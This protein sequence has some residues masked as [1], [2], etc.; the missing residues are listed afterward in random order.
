MFLP[1]SQA[2]ELPYLWHGKLLSLCGMI[3]FDILK[4]NHYTVPSPRKLLLIT[5]KG[6]GG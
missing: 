3:F 2:Q 5:T 1:Q 4:Q 6:C